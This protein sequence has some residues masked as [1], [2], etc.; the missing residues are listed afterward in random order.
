[1]LQLSVEIYNA[2]AVGGNGPF[3]FVEYITRTM[4][5]SDVNTQLIPLLD[6]TPDLEALFTQGRQ[7]AI[8]ADYLTEEAIFEPPEHLHGKSNT[9]SAERSQK[10]S[11]HPRDSQL[12]IFYFSVH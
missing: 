11:L 6:T 8:E 1:M 2:R 12:P 3:R 4:C 5:G 10:I 9:T 7:Y